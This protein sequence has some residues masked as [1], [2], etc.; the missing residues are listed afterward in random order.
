M[1]LQ[2]FSK[3]DGTSNQQQVVHMF[4][5]NVMQLLLLCMKQRAVTHTV[6]I[7]PLLLNILIGCTVKEVYNCTQRY[8]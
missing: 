4:M 7:I 6:Y 1:Y 3:G 5:D 2:P 8:I